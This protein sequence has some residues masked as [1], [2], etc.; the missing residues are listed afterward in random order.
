[1]EEVNLPSVDGNPSPTICHKKFQ[2][3]CVLLLLR[4]AYFS[5][6]GCMALVPVARRSATSWEMYLQL[7]CRVNEVMDNRFHKRA[8]IF[9]SSP[10]SLDDCSDMG[11]TPIPSL[12][13]PSLVVVLGAVDVSYA[14]GREGRRWR[15]KSTLVRPSPSSSSFSLPFKSNRNCFWMCLTLND[16]LI[17]S[18]NLFFD[19]TCHQFD[20]TLIAM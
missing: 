8:I 3:F 17:I 13:T 18:L 10:S 20:Y 15:A 1:M 2:Q 12:F 4:S 16:W 7:H 14:G 6:M 19:E 9:I 5:Q 11:S